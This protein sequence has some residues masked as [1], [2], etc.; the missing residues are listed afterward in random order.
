MKQMRAGLDDVSLSWLRSRK[1]A[2]AGSEL[3]EMTEVDERVVIEP[4]PVCS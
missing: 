4:E 2:E 3:I 1:S